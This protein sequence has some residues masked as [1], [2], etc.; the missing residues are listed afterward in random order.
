M[1]TNNLLT[2]MKYIPAYFPLFSLQVANIFTTAFGKIIYLKFQDVT[3][4]KP[5]SNEL[6]MYLVSIK[7]LHS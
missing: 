2:E 3:F 5:P 4:G 1:S 6:A 7:E